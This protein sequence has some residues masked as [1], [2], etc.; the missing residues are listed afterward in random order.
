EKHLATLGVE[1]R[2]ESREDNT[3][4]EYD[5]DNFSLFAQDEYQVLEALYLVMGARY[6]EHSEFGSELTPKVSLVWDINPHLKGKASYGRGFRAPNISELFITSWRQRGRVIYAANPELDPET[7]DSYEI[8]VEGHYGPFRGGLTLFRNDYKDLIEAEFVESLGSGQ[9]RKDYYILGNVA[10]ART[11]GLELRGD[12][13]LPLGFSLAAG[14]MWLDT[15]NRETGEELEGQPQ[16]KG[17]LKL[18]YHNTALRLNANIRAI[19]YGEAYGAAADEA[20]CALVHCYVAKEVCTNTKLF[21]GIDNLFDD[22]EREPT[23]FYSG[24]NVTF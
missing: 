24:I 5:A 3:G 13:T 20:D 7:S 19:Y 15:E 6:D 14:A 9:K 21:A 22:D 4:K 10:R 2:D 1:L 8:G 16:F 17:D 23:L 12:L 18:G 11:Q